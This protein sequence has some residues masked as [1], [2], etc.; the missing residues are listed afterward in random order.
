METNN[1]KDIAQL[2][3]KFGYS[4]PLSEEEVIAFE[5]KF[6]KDFESPSIWP[7][8]EDIIENNYSN[9]KKAIKLNDNNKSI[10]PLSMAAREGKEISN[11]IKEKMN[12][13]KNEAKK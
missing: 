9:T 13:D 12:K 3:K 11:E 2:L 10:I 1:N 6:E 8:I 5:S 4:M 7:S